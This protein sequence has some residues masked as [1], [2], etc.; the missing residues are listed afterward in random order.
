MPSSPLTHPPHHLTHIAADAR[1][2]SMRSAGICGLS[3]RSLPDACIVPDC[4]FANLANLTPLSAQAIFLRF[5]AQHTSSL[6]WVS[7]FPQGFM[8][9][10]SV[11][12]SKSCLVSTMVGIAAVMLSTHLA[13]STESV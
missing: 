12:I 6:Y 3:H 1:N 5:R 13:K 8:T 9:A 7:K 10:S 2:F 4:F 11:S